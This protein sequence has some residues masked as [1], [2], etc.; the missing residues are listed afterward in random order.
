MISYVVVN[1]NS[2]DFL[3]LLL[4]SISKFSSIDHEVIVID[5]SFEKKTLEVNSN[6]F[7]Y[8][9]NYNIGHGEGLN[10]GI[11][12]ATKKYILLLDVDCHFLY[13]NFDKL[14]IC[15]KEDII[16]VPG[17]IKKP[18]RPAFLFSKKELIENYDFNSSLNYKGNRIT[19]DGY[20]VGIL[21]YYKMLEE[22]RT[23][24]WMNKKKNRYKTLN[25]EE[26]CIN[27]I[28]IV[29]HHWH[30]SHLKE[31]QIDFPNDNLIE[32]KEKFMTKI[33]IEFGY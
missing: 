25:G 8:Y 9:Q 18:I 27:D 24:F 21:A 7:F 28:S 17:T 30:G 2:Y 10:L 20:D 26:Y 11:T 4:K 13:P 29:Y 16:T 15:Q 3:N 6:V 22:N 5:N 14:L 32:D 33:N 23:F 19:P 12:K 1:Y 31:R